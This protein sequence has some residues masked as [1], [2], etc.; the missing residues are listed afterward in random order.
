MITFMLKIILKICFCKFKLALGEETAFIQPDASSIIS[1]LFQFSQR[2][3]G[4]LFLLEI[5]FI[6][7]WQSLLLGISFNPTKSSSM[8]SN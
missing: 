5:T 6:S 7:F 2:I 8:D 4:R 3:T 1:F